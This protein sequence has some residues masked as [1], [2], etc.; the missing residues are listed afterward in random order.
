[1]CE[2]EYILWNNGENYRFNL[3][4]NLL[5]TIEIKMVLFIFSFNFK[6]IDFKIIANWNLIIQI[7]NERTIKQLK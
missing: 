6:I 4:L 7:F 3:L 5:Q 2:M 1:M